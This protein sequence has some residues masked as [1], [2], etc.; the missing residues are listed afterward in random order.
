[1]LTSNLLQRLTRAPIKS[2]LQMTLSTSTS[3]VLVE[4]E[5]SKRVVTLNRPK[6]LNALNVPMIREI[7]PQ[8]K[9]WEKNKDVNLIILK[10][11]GEKAFCAGG[12][13]VAVVKSAKAAKEGSTSTVHKDFFREEY[14][15]NYLIGSLSMP[16]V[17]FIDGIVMGGGCGLSVNGKFRVCTERTMLA[18]P[19]TALGLFPDVGGSYFLSRLKHNLGNY[20]ALTGYRLQGADALH[21]GLATHYVPSSQLGELQKKLVSLDD[22]TEKTVEAAIRELQPSSVPKFSVE[23]QLPVIEKTFQARTVEEILENLKKE[24]SDWSKKQVATLSKMSPTSMKVTLRQLQNG[25]NM[26]FN[27]VFTMEYQLTQRCLE[28]HDFYEGCRAILI[29]KDR[30]PK[31]KP[32]TLEEVTDEKVAWYFSPLGEGRDIDVTRPDAKF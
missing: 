14:F 19:E 10:G 32:A 24:N 18:M 17:A 6:A 23:Q 22:V 7:Y 4:K 5:G 15:L 26:K 8:M 13:V 27:E 1:M 3:E 31:W 11:A 9:Q 29:D 20:L 12:D 16:F 25:A 30:N 21:A 2:V 28:D